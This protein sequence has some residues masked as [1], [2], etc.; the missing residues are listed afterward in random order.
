MNYWNLVDHIFRTANIAE[1]SVHMYDMM[2]PFSYL[3]HI[4]RLNTEQRHK[5]ESLITSDTTLQA[6]THNH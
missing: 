4:N 1:H 2:I 6:N 3:E 5:D